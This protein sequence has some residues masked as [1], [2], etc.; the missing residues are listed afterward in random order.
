MNDVTQVAGNAPACY[1]SMLSTAKEVGASVKTLRDRTRKLALHLCTSAIVEN[2]QFEGLVEDVK[3][4]ARWPLMAKDERNR[5]NVFFTTC[6]TIIG[7]WSKLESD[8]QE[9]FLGGKLVY[10]TLASAIKK[11]EKEAEKTA[12]EAA[13]AEAAPASETE[14]EAA[15][16]PNA[17][18]PADRVAMIEAVTAM[19][20]ANGEG[21]SDA[22]MGA[23]VTLMAEANAFAARA[24]EAAKKAA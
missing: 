20:T 4:E 15:P 16:A 8:V 14:A 11:A 9:A 3:R 1:N 6:R 24:S 10:S 13:E 5:L 19:F 2:Y 22:E 21:L 12:Q 18:T 7:N 17:E 23:L